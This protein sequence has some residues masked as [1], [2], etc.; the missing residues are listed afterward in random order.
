V[1][2]TVLGWLLVLVA[3]SS[4]PSPSVPTPSPAT[5]VLPTPGDPHPDWPNTVV[6]AL[7]PGIGPQ[8]YA[9]GLRAF[10]RDLARG[11]ELNGEHPFEVAAFE[12]TDDGD[13]VKALVDGR[14]NAALLDAYWVVLARRQVELQVQQVALSAGQQTTV[15]GWIAVGDAYC[16]D[17][18][19][20]GSVVAEC[21]GANASNP[22]AGEQ[23][24][25]GLDG[26]RVVLG[27]AD[28]GVGHVVPAHQLRLAGIDPDQATVVAD[29][30]ARLEA[31]CTGAADVTVAPLPIEELPTACLGRSL[32]VFA[33]APEVPNPGIVTAGLP[34]AMSEQF[35]L[36]LAGQANCEIGFDPS[37]C[38]PFWVPI[39][40][41]VEMANAGSPDYGAVEASLER[42]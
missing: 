6:I 14:A 36:T 29:A 23:V 35:A 27:A 8:L 20:A 30:T 13:V 12:P 28:S 17:A 37:P 4:P 33:T 15:A 19:L 40:G 7:P 16:A 31:L 9:D 24:L 3:C 34:D 38:R 32:V 41:R 2:R 1:R 42:R 21:N 5:D 39:W 22:G 26:A 18:P 25:A 10:T 11:A